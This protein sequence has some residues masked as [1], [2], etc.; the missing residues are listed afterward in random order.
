MIQCESIHQMNPGLKD[1]NIDFNYHAYLELG[2]I[3][4]E[5]SRTVL[6]LEYGNL[7]CFFFLF[8]FP[9]NEKKL[10]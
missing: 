7:C 9:K 8:C 1:K 10:S 3:S 5:S 6:F 4:I 2:N